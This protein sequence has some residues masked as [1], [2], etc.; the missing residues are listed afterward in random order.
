MFKC[1]DGTCKTSKDLCPQES[2]CPKERPIFTDHGECVTEELKDVC[3]SFESYGFS[4]C[5]RTGHCYKGDEPPERRRRLEQ[6]PRKLQ[7]FYG[8][9]IEDEMSKCEAPVKS[10]GCPDDR[11]FKCSDGRCLVNNT[12]TEHSGACPEDAPYLCHNGQCSTS[13]LCEDQ[14]GTCTRTKC[15]NGQCV[16]NKSECI[17]LFNCPEKT[18]FLCSNSQCVSV[19]SQCPVSLFCDADKVN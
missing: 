17:N 11:P 19:P 5:Q 9:R 12:C 2:Y 4:Y 13:N 3:P 14:T 1:T 8:S 10:N 18:P 16:D 6:I 15:K 7:W